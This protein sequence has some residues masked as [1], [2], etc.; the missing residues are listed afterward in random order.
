[1]FHKTVSL[2]KY[3][4]LLNASYKSSQVYLIQLSPVYFGTRR[5]SSQCGLNIKNKK[6]INIAE[7]NVRTASPE[8][9]IDQ[10]LR[11]KFKLRGP[12]RTLHPPF[13][14][15]GNRLLNVWT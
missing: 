2:L 6:M 12:Q 1:M 7:W 5:V 9:K 3:F 4:P 11:K 15:S 10:M 13:P 14:S 8:N